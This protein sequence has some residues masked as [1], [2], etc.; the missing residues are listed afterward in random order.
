[1][2]E[3]LDLTAK[4]IPEAIDEAV[5]RARTLALGYIDEH[6]DPIV[7][8]RGSTHVYGPTQL[9]I[10]VRKRDSGFASAIESHPRVSLVYYGGHEGPGPAFLSFKG[11]ARV[12]ES[13]NDAVYDAMVELER[14]QD[15]A[16]KGVA[17][18]ID[19]DSVDGFVPNEGMFRMERSA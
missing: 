7:S 18:I 10:W 9:A 6:G 12:D 14:N 4:E 11:S 2:A 8:F 1:M 5:L 19:V 3:P 16:R 13:A 15:L 17:V